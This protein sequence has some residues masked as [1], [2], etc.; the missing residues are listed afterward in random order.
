[1]SQVVWNA[2]GE[3]MYETGVDRGVLYVDDNPGVPWNGIISV[4]EKSTGG[5]VSSYY[6]DGVKYLSLSMD[7]DFGLALEAYS[8]PPELDLCD[9]SGFV[10]IGLFSTMQ[11]RKAFG[12]TYR[13]KVGNDIDGTDLGYKIHLVYNA[14]AVPTDKKYSSQNASADAMSF[15]W[16]ISTTPLPVE[17]SNATAHLVIDSTKAY[18]WAVKAL[19]DVIYGTADQDPR[20]PLPAEVVQL[21]EDSSILKIT[22][23]GDGTWTATGPDSVVSMIDANSFQISWP[24]AVFVDDAHT[25]YLLTSL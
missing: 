11:P 4:D 10:R 8:S 17:G 12:F 2:Y 1:M 6:L 22:D 16:D 20:L 15:T 18:D 9:G 13:T 7:Q 21:F 25:Q 14:I 19:E 24:S 3:R 5:S 23:N